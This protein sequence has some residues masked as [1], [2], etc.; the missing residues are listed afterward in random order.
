MIEKSLSTSR[1]RLNAP[2][3]PPVYPG[4]TADRAEEPHKSSTSTLELLSLQPQ[5]CSALIGHHAS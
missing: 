3:V 2:V 1:G 4:L 5:L